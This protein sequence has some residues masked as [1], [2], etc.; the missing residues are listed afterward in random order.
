MSSQQENGHGWFLGRCHTGCRLARIGGRASV[1]DQGSPSRYEIQ[2]EGVLDSRW[3]DWFGNLAVESDGR[4]TVISGLIADQAAL[5][6]LLA[7]IRDLGLC[8]VSVRRTGSGETWH[9][10]PASTDDAAAG[11]PRPPAK[12]EPRD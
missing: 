6:G 9:P 5:H 7:K 4:R 12:G 3:A 1:S 2:V 10:G 11:R 8:L